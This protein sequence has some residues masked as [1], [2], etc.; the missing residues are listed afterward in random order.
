MLAAGQ[1]VCVNCLVTHLLGVECP[2]IGPPKR[3]KLDSENE[4]EEAEKR[5][6]GAPKT[7]EYNEEQRLNRFR[8][9]IRKC[10][11]KIAN[12]RGPPIGNKA[13]FV[14][15]YFKVIFQTLEGTGSKE[16]DDMIEDG[17][18][19]SDV[20]AF[21]EAILAMILPKVD[22]ERGKAAV[23]RRLDAIINICIAR[24]EILA[25]A[26]NSG[27]IEDRPAEPEEDVNVR[28]LPNAPEPGA[29]VER[30]PEIGPNGARRMVPSTFV[31]RLYFTVNEELPSWKL[32]L[33]FE[34]EPLPSTRPR[35]TES[36][37][38]ARLLTASEEPFEGESKFYDQFYAETK[39]FARPGAV[40]MTNPGPRWD[41]HLDSQVGSIIIPRRLNNIRFWKEKE[42]NPGSGR[43]KFFI[44]RTVL[45]HFYEPTKQRFLQERFLNT[46]ESKS[47]ERPLQIFERWCLGGL[48]NG[49]PRDFWRQYAGGLTGAKDD[50]K[51][52]AITNTLFACTR[53]HIPSGSSVPWDGFTTNLFA[54]FRSIDML[55]AQER[56]LDLDVELSQKE[57]P[58][59]QSW[60]VK[61]SLRK[62]S[63]EGYAKFK[64]EDLQEQYSALFSEEPL[65]RI[66][67]VEEKPEVWQALLDAFVVADLS[68]LDET[69]T[70]RNPLVDRYWDS[71]VSD[72][73]IRE[74]FIKTLMYK[75]GESDM[76]AY[77]RHYSAKTP[78]F[79]KDP[80]NYFWLRQLNSDLTRTINRQ[81]V[82][83][84][85]Q[86]PMNN[87]KMSMMLH[88]NLKKELHKRTLILSTPED[89]PEHVEDFFMIPVC[90]GADDTEGW[91]L[92][93]ANGKFLVET[94]V[95][96]YL[97][98]LG[99]IDPE[100]FTQDFK[101]RLAAYFFDYVWEYVKMD[102]ETGSYHENLLS[103]YTFRAMMEAMYENVSVFPALNTSFRKL[104]QF[105]VES[106][107]LCREVS[108][109]IVEKELEEEEQVIIEEISEL[110]EEEEAENV[111]V[112][113]L[114][115]EVRALTGSKVRRKLVNGFN[116]WKKTRLPKEEEQLMEIMNALEIRRA[117]I[118][119]FAAE[120]DIDPLEMEDL[121]LEWKTLNA[122]YQPDDLQSELIRLF[123]E[124]SSPLAEMIV[125]A[126]A[127]QLKMEEAVANNTAWENKI[128]SKPRAGEKRRHKVVKETGPS[129]AMAKNLEYRKAIWE[130]RYLLEFLKAFDGETADQLLEIPLHDL[131]YFWRRRSW[132]RNRITMFV[133]AKINKD[134][135]SRV[136][137]NLTMDEMKA[138]EGSFKL[139]TP[140]VEFIPDADYVSPF[141]TPTRP[142]REEPKERPAIIEIPAEPEPKKP[143]PRKRQPPS[144]P[145]PS[146]VR[147]ASP[148]RHRDEPS[149]VVE[150]TA[151]EEIERIIIQLD[152]VQSDTRKAIAEGE[153]EFASSLRVDAANLREELGRMGYVVPNHNA[154]DE[155]KIDDHFKHVNIRNDA[156]IQELRTA[157]EVAEASAI[158]LELDNEF[159]L[160][161]EQWTLAFRLRAQLAGKLVSLPPNPRPIR[162]RQ[163]NDPVKE[164][165][166]D[167]IEERE[168]KATMA[169]ADGDTE[170]ARVYWDN[171]QETRDELKL[172]GV[173]E[174][175]QPPKPTALPPNLNSETRANEARARQIEIL[176]K[177]AEENVYLDPEKPIPRDLQEAADIYRNSIKDTDE[178]VAV[179]VK[180]TDD[181]EK[182]DL[183]H[184]RTGD[185]IKRRSRLMKERTKIQET[186]QQIRRKGKE[187]LDLLTRR[188]AQ[189]L[190]L[191]KEQIEEDREMFEEFR[192]TRDWV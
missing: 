108:E 75:E 66:P 29:E 128:L 120:H 138:Y 55:A 161:Y 38:Q 140:V 45:Q 102:L 186:I 105:D 17:L 159:E 178:L 25:N 157:L 46:I 139:P 146:P 3:Q 41:D 153:W 6:R 88:K 31:L 158:A 144:R 116:A 130:E 163:T 174:W 82:F 48:A 148:R 23:I 54:L 121:A 61:K 96:C 133:Q 188:N 123:E 30:S 135:G 21:K 20:V 156:A 176:R 74:L 131:T 143:S 189:I 64:I 79:L 94:L 49:M 119:A 97:K 62:E 14:S 110:E 91:A 137:K 118:N 10:L 76:N 150:L 142:Q 36:H 180:L 125:K 99:L 19:D 134:D 63:P 13:E 147:P 68:L 164:K 8:K 126:K 170:L 9:A 185:D 132:L 129:G 65:F 83:T 172:L 191:T 53:F 187:A 1:P 22:T 24:D 166:M 18:F 27:T 43:Y 101:E 92:K 90:T 78:E 190:V 11:I 87:F 93:Y 56:Q 104:V 154:T 37:R 115:Q 47:S 59:F 111:D 103:E 4:E 181:V 71:Y 39:Q 28:S 69:H 114:R 177:Q 162:R 165:M 50:E 42:T 107:D 169:E 32:F 35:P 175:D 60:I 44:K 109:S 57:I 98:N 192:R 15:G 113:L 168:R 127:K 89:P 67:F 7:V 16:L 124:P 2:F 152:R 40:N 112:G 73:E 86:F 70:K 122:Q 84:I 136:W 85:M 160:A 95:S 100:L 52:L 184:D 182:I 51:R 72:L 106:D 171:A 117:E 173:F 81:R 179:E 151:S 155:Q 5:R 141:K 145:I 183:S 149:T 58:L 80:V 12:N 77:M 167:S 26:W 33:A 34:Y